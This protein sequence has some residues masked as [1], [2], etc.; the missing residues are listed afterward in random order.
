M[1]LLT[2]LAFESENVSTMPTEEITDIITPE[3][4]Q[5]LTKGQILVFMDGKKKTELRITKIKSGRVWATEVRTYS[6]DE[7]TIV[8]NKV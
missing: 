6:P 8:E 5:K 4:L 7:V 3:G 2:F 1:G